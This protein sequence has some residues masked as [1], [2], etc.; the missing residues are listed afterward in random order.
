[1]SKDRARKLVTYSHSMQHIVRA[2]RGLNCSASF[3][4]LVKLSM[5]ELVESVVT[6]SC[7]GGGGGHEGEGGEHGEIKQ[8]VDA[9]TARQGDQPVR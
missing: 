8:M 7:V 9:A 6:D 1:M 2:E 5:M 3:H 4:L